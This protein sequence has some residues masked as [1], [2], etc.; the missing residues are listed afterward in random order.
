MKSCPIEVF[1]FP[2]VKILPSDFWV[3]SIWAKKSEKGFVL[4]FWIQ[5]CLMQLQ[6]TRSS[7]SWIPS[8]AWAAPGA[9]K[10]LQKSSLSVMTIK[11]SWFGAVDNRPENRD[12]IWCLCSFSGNLL[13]CSLSVSAAG[14]R[15]RLSPDG[16]PP[17]VTGVQVSAGGFDLGALFSALSAIF[18]LPEAPD[19]SEPPW[20]GSISPGLPMAGRDWSKS[21][22]SSLEEGEEFLVFAGC[23]P[24]AGVHMRKKYPRNISEACVCYAVCHLW[25]F[26]TGW[27][28]LAPS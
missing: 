8:S 9:H 24:W 3:V 7:R 1:E 26:G 21:I 10:S 18:C 12:L 17:E 2:R 22:V 20:P 16:F 27:P 25:G 6:K 28:S 19:G 4:L 5:L 15:Q 13:G 11:T 14:S 23:T